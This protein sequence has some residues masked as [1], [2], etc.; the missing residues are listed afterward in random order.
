MRGLPEYLRVD[1]YFGRHY[2]LRFSAIRL[3]DHTEDKQDKLRIRAV[4]AGLAIPHE[5][6]TA[7]A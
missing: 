5:P 6:G 7:R 4:G 3:S 1:V 2:A